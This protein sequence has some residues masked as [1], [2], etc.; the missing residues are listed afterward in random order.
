MALSGNSNEWSYDEYDQWGGVIPHAWSDSHQPFSYLFTTFSWSGEQSIEGNYT[1][2]KLKISIHTDE[3][4]KSASSSNYFTIQCFGI[5]K[6]LYVK[7]MQ[8]PGVYEHEITIRVNHNNDGTKSGDIRVDWACD[9]LWYSGKNLK[10]IQCRQRSITLNAIPR[11]STM[12]FPEFEAGQSGEFTI[13]RASSSFTHTLQ[14]PI[15][16]N[17]ATNIGT[18]YTWTPPM[19]LC[20]LFPDA[21]SGTVTVRL[22]TYNGST[23]IGYRDY[24]VTIKVP[25]NVVPDFSFSLS[26]GTES[27]FGVYVASLSTVKATL[28]GI[29]G[30]YGSTVKK[31]QMNV[32]ETEYPIDVDAASEVIDSNTIII[33][34]SSKTITVSITD[35]RGRTKTKSTAITVYEYAEPQ[36]T[37]IDLDIS[38][39][40]VVIKVKGKI[41]PVNNLNQKFITI[42]KI[43]TSTEQG[44][45]VVSRTAIAAYSFNLSF[46]ETVQDIST[47]SYEYIVTLEDKINEISATHLSGVICISRYAG[48]KGVAFF[49]EAD[50]E[51]IDMSACASSKI[52]L[53]GG[54]TMQELINL[55]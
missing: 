24:E 43:N 3:I 50:K 51:G 48:G 41:S 35:S 7:N 11:T 2:V 1:D 10:A 26:E 54:H 27:G 25:T 31:A 46:T 8:A 13:S 15:G 23:Q 29:T 14:Y 44:S 53:A 42:E 22:I 37:D 4:Y 39:T 30:A 19:S 32:D 21:T 34:A 12:T 38:G 47:N 36:I 18:S 52:Y 16:T 40:T 20:N 17:I 9:P 45:V 33:P 49:K 5:T 55:L 28:T 6:T